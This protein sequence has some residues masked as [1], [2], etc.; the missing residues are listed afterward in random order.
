MTT[1]PQN[2]P[3]EAPSDPQSPAPEP[4]G[5]SSPPPESD[6]PFEVPEL[7]RIIEAAFDDE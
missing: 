7:D 2:P 3:N 5:D 4:D 6:T 1:D